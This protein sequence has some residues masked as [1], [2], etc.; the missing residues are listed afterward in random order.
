M[1]TGFF[2]AQKNSAVP[3]EVLAATA[4]VL[5]LDTGRKLHHRL[6]DSP[7]DARQW[8]GFEVDGS[9]VETVRCGWTRPEIDDLDL[10]IPGPDWARG[11]CHELVLHLANGGTLPYQ[12]ELT[13]F[14]TATLVSRSGY[15]LTNHHLVTGPQKTHGIP[16][17]SFDTEG[18]PAPH[19]RILTDNRDDLGPV[20][21]CYVDPELDLAVLKI[22]PTDH[23][24]PVAITGSA[25]P[26]HERVWQWGY[27]HRSFRSKS[28][29]EFLGFEEANHELRYSP[30]LVI[31]GAGQREWFSDGDAVLGS[32]GSALLN[33]DGQL[34]GIYRGGGSQ[35]LY[36]DHPYRYRRCVDVHHLKEPL[37]VAIAPLAQTS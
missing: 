17:R 2:S 26:L 24:A 1:G 12:T 3:A 11:F 16:A 33:D 4:S 28:E 23:I 9:G 29:R 37:A 7:E 8:S 25:P 27:P 5:R 13:G 20:R 35:D 14:G 36:P 6:F 10:Q 32:S 21:V 30:G 22:E 34:V 31:A 18:V 19:L 15:L